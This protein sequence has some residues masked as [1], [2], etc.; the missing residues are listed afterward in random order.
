M[1]RLSRTEVR[2][3][4]LL[5]VAAIFWNVG[6]LVGLV[7]IFKGDMIGVEW[8]EM[9]V[10]S[11]PILVVSYAMIGI[12]G[13]ISFRFR[14]NEHVYVSQWYLL[15]ALFWFPWLYTIAQLMIIFIPA[16]GVVQAITNWWFA[17]NVLGLF[18]T[19]VGLASIYYFMPKVLG[20][21]IHSYYLSVLGF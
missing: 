20:K 6:V 5:Y 3:L 11:S 1:A 15:A 16:R 12:W 18:M 10:Y 4:G 13:L 14:T 7:G 17:H 2:H 21:P 8:L 9:P 19:P